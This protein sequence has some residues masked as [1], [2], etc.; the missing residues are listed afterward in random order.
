MLIS[1]NRLISNQL[2]KLINEKGLKDIDI[3]K[4]CGFTRP[5]LAKIKNE[6]NINVETLVALANGLGVK[7]GYFF[8]EDDNANDVIEFK[9]KQN[10]QAKQTN[11]R[12]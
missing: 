5:T 10:V 8:G 4:K 3:L 12:P 7:V 1:V 9:G 6:G 11:C 2:S